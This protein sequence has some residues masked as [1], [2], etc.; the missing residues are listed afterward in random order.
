[1]AIMS[2]CKECRRE[3]PEKHFP[4]CQNPEKCK[5]FGDYREK[6]DLAN[7]ERSKEHAARWTA[8]SRARRDKWI[9]DGNKM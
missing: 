6:L 1:M 3:T 5:A 8:A 4:G 7:M 2:P 9:K